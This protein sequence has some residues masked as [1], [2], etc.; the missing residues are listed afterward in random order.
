MF[1]KALICMLIGYCLGK[2]QS[3]F[4]DKPKSESSS[5][6]QI[7]KPVWLSNRLFY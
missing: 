4:Q 6:Q 1:K 5:P 2:T 7:S 3:F